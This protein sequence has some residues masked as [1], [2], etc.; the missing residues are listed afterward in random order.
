MVI[1]IKGF[2][3]TIA[4]FY[5]ES[6]GEA[7]CREQVI[8]ICGVNVYINKI[9]ALLYYHYEAIERINELTSEFMLYDFNRF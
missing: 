9:D 1:I 4:S 5:W 7:F 2:Y 3:P 6:T 8:P